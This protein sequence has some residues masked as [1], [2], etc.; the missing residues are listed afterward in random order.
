MT[1]VIPPELKGRWGAWGAIA[2]RKELEAMRS[3][4]TNNLLKVIYRGG[5]S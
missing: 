3:H 4:R 5:A 1:L 2:L